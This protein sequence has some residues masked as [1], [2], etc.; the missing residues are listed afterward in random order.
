M[1]AEECEDPGAI[2]I[3]RANYD[4][5]IRENRQRDDHL[6]SLEC[7][8][9]W[10]QVA[11]RDSRAENDRRSCT[12]ERH[13][14]PESGTEGFDQSAERGR[15]TAACELGPEILCR[16]DAE[17]RVQACHDVPARQHLQ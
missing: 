2:T 1:S 4:D 6:P 7:G 8:E 14:A 9:A 15:I 5:D 13:V 12:S 17:N 3:H 16:E 10:N 11:G